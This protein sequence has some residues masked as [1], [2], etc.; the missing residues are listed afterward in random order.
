MTSQ[1]TDEKQKTFTLYKTVPHCDQVTWRSI[2]TCCGITWNAMCIYTTLRDN[3]NYTA[4]TYTY[5]PALQSVIY[6]FH[7]RVAVAVVRM[8]IL[9]IVVHSHACCCLGEVDK[10]MGEQTYNI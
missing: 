7:V 1:I 6:I 2:L 3:K 10:G 9:Q 4:I 5:T 8:S